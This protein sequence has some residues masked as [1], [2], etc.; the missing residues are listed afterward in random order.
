MKLYERNPTHAECT[1]KFR[2]VM[3]MNP[4][5]KFFQPQ[6]FTAPWHVKARVNGSDM[7]FWPHLLKGQIAHEKAVVGY[8]EILALIGEARS[9]MLDDLIEQ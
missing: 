5:I 9:R 1:R 6:P 3:A 2:D 8:R 4:D 7:N